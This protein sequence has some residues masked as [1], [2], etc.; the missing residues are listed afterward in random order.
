M[1]CVYE[2][3]CISTR[4]SCL[5]I[6]RVQHMYACDLMG[7]YYYT[8]LYRIYIHIAECIYKILFIIIIRIYIIYCCKAIVNNKLIK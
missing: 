5:L 1:W 6:A 2:Q 8:Y 3:T 7:D 4:E